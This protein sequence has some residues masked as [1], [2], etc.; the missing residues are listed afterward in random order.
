MFCNLLVATYQAACCGCP[1]IR[2]DGRNKVYMS[3]LVNLLES[4]HFEDR[5]SCVDNIRMHCKEISF[6]AS[7]S[8]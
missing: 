1:N 7:G 8:D 4:G 5:Y 3:L 2:R 6:K